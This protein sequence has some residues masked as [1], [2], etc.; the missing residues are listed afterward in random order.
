MKTEIFDLYTDYLIGSFGGVTATGLSE[1]LNGEVSHDQIT[2]MLR[3]E[4]KGSVDL[5][6]KVKPL[7]RRYETEEGSLVVDDSIEEKPYTDENELISWHWDSSK[8][9]AIKGINFI[10]VMYYAEE[11]RLPVTY[12]LVEKTET[13]IDRKT[14]KTRRRSNVS[15]NTRMRRMLLTDVTQE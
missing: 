12:E 14:G 7:I 15:K 9:K 4:A 13:Y 1:V 10:T 5:W 2:R 8:E 3:E 6:Q 11:I